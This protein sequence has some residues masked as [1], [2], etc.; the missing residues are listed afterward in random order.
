[1]RPRQKPTRSQSFDEIADRLGAAVSRLTGLVRTSLVLLLLGQGLNDA[2]VNA[3]NTPNMIYELILG[4]IL[5]ATLVPLFTDD[6]EHDGRDGATDAI[7]SFA[8]VALLVVTVVAAVAAPL[9]IL[10]F[11]T[12]SD[13]ANRPDY[14]AAGV[15]LALLFAPQVFFY[16]LMALWSAVLNARHRFLAAAW[17][18][19]L[20][21]IIAIATLIVAGQMTDGTPTLEDALGARSRHH[22]RYRGHGPV[23]VPGGSPGGCTPALQLRSEAPRG[24]QDREPVG[25]DLRLRHGQPGVDRGDPDPGQAVVG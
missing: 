5:T 4:G 19:V 14:I 18:P 20:N 21:N 23:P 2:Y 7:L 17:A 22:C 9:L 12:G 24:P 8:L 6:L 13:P 10:L 11:A 16:G 1:M 25:V 15:P 3:N